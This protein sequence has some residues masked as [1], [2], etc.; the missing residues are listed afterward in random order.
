MAAVL[1]DLHLELPTC[2]SWVLSPCQAE[3][4]P[5]L[6]SLHCHLLRPCASSAYDM[7]LPLSLAQDL[8]LS[9]IIREIP[10]FV[11]IRTRDIVWCQTLY[12]AIAYLGGFSLLSTILLMRKSKV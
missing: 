4:S 12:E 2:A 1:P 8:T 6:H 10:F 9:S 7:L 3:L 11:H 5:G